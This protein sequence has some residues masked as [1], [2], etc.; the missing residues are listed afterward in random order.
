MSSQRHKLDQ[1][2]ATTCYSTRAHKLSR[3]N[4]A[5]TYKPHG[6]QPTERKISTRYDNWDSLMASQ[7]TL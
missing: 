5:T 3:Y 2:L 1:L 6:W 7:Q 4:Y